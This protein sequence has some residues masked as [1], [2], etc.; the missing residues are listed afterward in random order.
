VSGYPIILE[1]SARLAVVVGGGPVGCR[2]VEGLLAAGARVRLISLAPP[3]LVL[4][5]AV[6]LCRKAF[7]PADLDGAVLAFAATGSAAVDQA[8]IAAARARSIPVNAAAE[9]AAGDFAL[10]AVLSRGDLLL[11][12]ATHGRSPALSRLLR[13]QLAAA[14]GPEWALV[15]EIVGRLRTRKLTESPRETYNSEILARLLAA[16][17]PQLL[18]ERRIPA[19]DRLLTDACGE[20]TSLAQLGLDLRDPSS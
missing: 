18:A 9:P 11:A 8:V 16:G 5:A 7:A 17:L 12:V 10:P 6:E 1:L 19:I 3:A 14:Y 2:K 13:D 20:E 4:P 15:V